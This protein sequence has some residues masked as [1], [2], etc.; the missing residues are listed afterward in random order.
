MEGLLSTGP[1][2]SSCTSNVYNFADNTSFDQFHL[3][4]THRSFGGSQVQLYLWC[5]LWPCQGLKQRQGLRFKYNKQPSMTPPGLHHWDKQP[6][7]NLPLA[8]RP[9]SLSSSRPRRL[10]ALRTSPFIGE[11]QARDGIKAP[12]ADSLHINFYKATADLRKTWNLAFPI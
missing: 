3:S 11:D 4:L 1:T 2:P 9:L 6:S 5:L 12:N 10:L 8:P 7:T